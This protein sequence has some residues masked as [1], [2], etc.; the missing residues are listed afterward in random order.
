MDMKIDTSEK[1]S[2]FCAE[3]TGQFVTVDYNDDV[4]ANISE[5]L[6]KAVATK[7]DEVQYETDEIIESEIRKSIL[8]ALGIEVVVKHGKEN[9]VLLTEL[10][11]NPTKLETQNENEIQSNQ[12][13]N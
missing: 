6:D 5:I 12:N 10:Y 4:I 11:G 1:T 2:A 13:K 3:E 7:L 8:A 9:E